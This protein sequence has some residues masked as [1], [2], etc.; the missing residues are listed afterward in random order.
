M[1]GMWSGDKPSNSD[2][3]PAVDSVSAIDPKL[4]ATAVQAVLGTGA[5]LIFSATRDYGAI[6][7]TLLDGNDRHKVYATNVQEL[8]QALNDLVESMQPSRPPT[9]KVIPKR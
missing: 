6:C 5:A 4:I 9:H 7:L 8:Q 1:K 2:Y 3:K